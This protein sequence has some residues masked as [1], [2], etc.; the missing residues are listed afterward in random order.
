M[1]KTVTVWGAREYKELRRISTKGGEQVMKKGFTLIELLIVIAI[2]GI[3]VALILPR[4][5]DIRE[6]ANTKVCVANL[7]GLV[8]AMTT[9]E[10]RWNTSRSDWNTQ[11][12]DGL[13]TMGYLS[14]AVQCPLGGAYT[15]AAGDPPTAACPNVGDAPTHAWP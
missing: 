7:R 8:S 12:V 11:G 2:L 14:T 1:E 5:T 15:L 13:V 4:F 9:Y 10:T 3:L 6:D